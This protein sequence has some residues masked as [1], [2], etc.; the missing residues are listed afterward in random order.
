VGGA[1]VCFDYVWIQGTSMASPHA[2]GVAALIRARDPELP[3]LAVIAE[4]QNT[5]M[6]MACPTLT[7][8]EFAAFFP[9]GMPDCSGTQN[10][11]ANGSETNWY[12][13]GL[14]D[15]LA[16]ATGERSTDYPTEPD[17]D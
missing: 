8:A 11:T 17:L 14:T 15:A 10:P 7:E 16:A 2:A 4:M 3:P 1:P 12:G 13:N 6:A 9:L 5:A